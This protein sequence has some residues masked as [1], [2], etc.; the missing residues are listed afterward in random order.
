MVSKA[1]V[2]REKGRTWRMVHRKILGLCLEVVLVTPPNYK[3]DSEIWCS[4]QREGMFGKQL[5]RLWSQRETSKGDW[6]RLANVVLGKSVEHDVQEAKWRKD[7][8]EERMVNR[9]Q[10]C[11]KVKYDEGWK[12][13]IG[14]L[15]L[16]F[17]VTL[18]R[19]EWVEWWSNELVE[20]VREKNK[21]RKLH[22]V[23]TENSFHNMFSVDTHK[24]LSAVFP[25]MVVGR[26]RI[27]SRWFK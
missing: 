13:T 5:S 3:G 14:L 27:H 17:L 6:E 12:L 8:K 11:W 10:C 21:E 2:G 16:T 15:L 23:G 25:A 19:A 7:F 4:W 22:S 9:V 18:T 20:W 24:G 26:N 1:I